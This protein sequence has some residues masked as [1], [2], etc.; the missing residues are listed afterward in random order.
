MSSLIK[1]YA[2]NTSELALAE[3]VDTKPSNKETLGL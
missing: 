3:K 1:N 2:E